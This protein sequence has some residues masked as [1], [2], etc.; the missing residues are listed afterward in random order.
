MPKRVSLSGQQLSM[1]DISLHY[2]DFRQSLI[3][4]FDNRNLSRFS[5]YTTSELI[6]ELQERLD[7]IDKISAFN[8]LAAIEAA[9]RVDYLHRCQ[10]RKKDKLSRKFR[11]A[12]KARGP[13]IGL[14]DEI[15]EIWKTHDPDLRLIIGH[16]RGALKFRHWL[17]HGRYWEPKLGQKYDFAVVY[18]LA[19]EVLK[20]FPLE[21]RL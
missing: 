8:T 12:F 6:A 17:A 9:L 15:L 18:A 1:E 4:Y 13:R 14:E 5:G 21:S 20:S 7:E 2:Q 16:L 19:E 11:T 3:A 10:G